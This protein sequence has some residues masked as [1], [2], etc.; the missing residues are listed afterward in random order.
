MRRLLLIAL[1]L[2]SARVATAADHPATTVILVRHA[3]KAAPNGDPPLTDAGSERAKELARL[4]SDANVR[5]IYVTQ[6]QRTSLTA[7]PLAKASGITPAIFKTGD[8]YAK[9]VVDDILARHAGETVLVVGHNNTTADVMRQ[10]GI[11]DAK[12]IP[13]TEFD[14]L[15]V[16]VVRDGLATLVRLRYGAVAR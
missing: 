9:A 7:E 8:G 16:C 5:G 12:T 1:L 11:A 10:L 14:N 3:E 15:F 6:Y 13:D 4:L 2:V